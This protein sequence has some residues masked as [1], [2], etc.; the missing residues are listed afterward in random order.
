MVITLYIAGNPVP[1]KRTG[2]RRLPDRVITY[3]R[4]TK[5]KEQTKWQI[6]AQYDEEP[7]RTPISMVITFCMPIPVGTSRK[8]VTQMRSGYIKHMCR[9]D[10]DNLAKYLLDVMTGTVYLDDAQ[11]HELILRKIYSNNPRSVVQI[12]PETNNPV[13]ESTVEQDDFCG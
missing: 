5:E 2:Q 11:I 7:I 3:D 1:W 6:V 10:V 8:R 12:T 13:V 9:P 4:Q